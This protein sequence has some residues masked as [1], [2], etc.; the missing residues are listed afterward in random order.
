LTPWPPV[1]PSAISLPWIIFWSSWRHFGVIAGG[2]GIGFAIPI[3]MASVSE[4][5]QKE[6]EDEYGF[7]ATSFKTDALHLGLMRYNKNQF[8]DCRESIRRFYEISF[9]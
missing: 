6:K 4:N 9:I 8:D 5:G 1:S 2:Q 3:G 7:R